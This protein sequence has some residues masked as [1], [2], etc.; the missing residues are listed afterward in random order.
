MT[1]QSGW[2]RR[3]CGGRDLLAVAL[4]LI[5]STASWS[6]MHFVDRMFLFWHSQ[7]EMAAA[8]DYL[9][10]AQSQHHNFLIQQLKNDPAWDGLRTESRFKRLLADLNLSE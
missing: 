1:D 7:D 2:W 9:E 3:E 5:L 8:L 4:P 10:Q 6:I